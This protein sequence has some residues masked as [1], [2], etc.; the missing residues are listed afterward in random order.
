MNI[1]IMSKLFVKSGVGFHIKDLTSELVKKGNRVYIISVNNE[2]TEFCKENDIEFY[3]VN[4]TV[5]PIMFIKNLLYLKKF[6]SQ[7]DID[8]V[9]CHHRTCGLYMK[10]LSAIT[11]VPFVWSNHLDNIPSDFIHRKTTFYGKQCICVSSDLKKFCVKKLGIPENKISVVLNGI[12]PENY[13]Y[14]VNYV[15]DF[16]AKNNIENEKIIGLFARMAPIKGHSVLIEALAGMKLDCLEKIRVIF[17]GGTDGEYVMSL[18]DQIS[19]KNLDKYIIFEGFVSPSQALSLSDMTV[20]PSIKEGFAIVTIES[21][22]M[23][24]PHIRTKTAGYEDLKAGCVGIEIN[25]SEALKLELEKFIEGKNYTEMVE[26]G[27]NLA[28]D[29]CTVEKMTEQILGIYQI[30]IDRTK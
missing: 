11:G 17:F 14:D 21:Y 4:F 8:I 1:L 6:I 2:H 22:L 23:H 19:E 24:K 7:K 20:L 28:M 26:S 12:H 25:D 27:Y 18:K 13:V 29:R 5:S 9:H 3:K 16:K 15:N 10:F 30:A